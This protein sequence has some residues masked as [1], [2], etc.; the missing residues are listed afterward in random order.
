MLRP[1]ELARG[2]GRALARVPCGGHWLRSGPRGRRWR[3]SPVVE[4]L[5]LGLHNC[6]P[7]S[8]RPGWPLCMRGAHAEMLESLLYG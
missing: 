4:C 8:H 1:L 7:T 3:R 6:M 5:S 2:A